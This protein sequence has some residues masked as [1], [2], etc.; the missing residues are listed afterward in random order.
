MVSEDKLPEQLN[1]S[2]VRERLVTELQYTSGLDA[3]YFGYEITQE[4][5]FAVLYSEDGKPLDKYKIMIEI[6]KV[7]KK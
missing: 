3:T 1:V 4:G 5:W 7:N 2:E 6:T